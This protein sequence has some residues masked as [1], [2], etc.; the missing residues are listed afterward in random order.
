[1]QVTTRGDGKPNKRCCDRRALVETKIE[2]TSKKLMSRHRF[3]VA[4]QKEDIVGRNREIMS[5]PA[6][7]AEWTCN[8]SARKFQVATKI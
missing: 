7:N 5:R 1:M 6:S 8:V 2:G 3:E 4:T